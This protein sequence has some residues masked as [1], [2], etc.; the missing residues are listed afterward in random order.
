MLR[1][2]FL[3]PTA[4]PALLL[5][6]LLLSASLARGRESQWCRD[7]RKK[8][9]RGCP[10]GSRVMFDCVDQDGGCC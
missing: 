2:N 3:V 10:S 5:G 8:C 9:T 7:Q 1:R 4:I 6:V